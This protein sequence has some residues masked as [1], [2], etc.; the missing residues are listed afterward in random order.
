MILRVFQAEATA[1]VHVEPTHYKS[2]RRARSN[3]TSSPQSTTDGRRQATDE[4]TLVIKKA[5]QQ[6]IEYDQVL[7]IQKKD[8][9][10]VFPA[11]FFQ[12][13]MMLQFQNSLAFVE[14]HHHHHQST[15]KQSNEGSGESLNMES[16]NGEGF[17]GSPHTPCE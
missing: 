3:A 2:Q 1:N 16:E 7:K 17:L 14:A 15:E 11:M 4:G 9:E 5:G 13:L 12:C 10:N 6:L 8:Y